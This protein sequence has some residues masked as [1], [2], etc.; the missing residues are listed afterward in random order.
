MRFDATLRERWTRAGEDDWRFDMPTGW[1]Q[2]RSVFGG[3][4]V[5]AAAA[6]A[7][8]QVDESRLLRTVSSHLMQPLLPGEVHGAARVLREGGSVS[9][10]EV[11]LAQK[12][13]VTAKVMAVFG[14]PRDTE[15]RVGGPTFEGPGPDEGMELPYVEGVTPEFTQHVAM[16]WTEGTPPFF[17]A[18]EARFAG[19]CRFR[20]PAG[21]D[22]GILGLLDAWPPPTLS[23]LD[24]P[25][26][27]STVTWT[28]HVLS[29]PRD[30][31]G[32]FGFQYETLA[33][34]A[35][36]HTAVGKLYAPD[37]QLV[38]F[39]EQLMAVFA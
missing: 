20:V 8:R 24:R 15:V 34:S 29:V 19:Y 25:A 18:D 1:L 3:I 32:W 39:T 5:A 36:F 12:G 27:A 30:F 4:S 28:A 6:L 16:R 10:V 11:S 14:K 26:P 22:E 23:I 13:E 35:G 33:G 31:D 37:G 17:S 2:G 21:D 38:A 9:F 7:R